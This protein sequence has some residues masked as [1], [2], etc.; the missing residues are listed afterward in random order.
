MRRRRLNKK[1][2]YDYDR[3]FFKFHHEAFR[4]KIRDSL[5]RENMTMENLIEK[6]G[7]SRERIDLY[8]TTNEK[9]TVPEFAA[10]CRALNVTADYLFDY[11]TDDPQKRI[12]LPLEYYIAQNRIW[13]IK[14]SKARRFK[15]PWFAWGTAR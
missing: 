5:K 2:N 3:E 7:V 1:W 14:K 10:L 15:F 11:S 6:S 4:Q 8:Y 9:P 12:L 13:E